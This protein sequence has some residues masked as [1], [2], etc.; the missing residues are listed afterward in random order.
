MGARGVSVGVRR[1][2]DR[3][4]SLRSL[5]PRGAGVPAVCAADSGVGAAGRERGWLRVCRAGVRTDLLVRRG[6]ARQALPDLLACG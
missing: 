3:L 6:A 1:R 4:S 5:V 2:N